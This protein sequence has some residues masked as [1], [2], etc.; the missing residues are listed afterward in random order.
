[1]IYGSFF[2]QKFLLVWKLEGFCVKIEYQNVISKYF[3][4]FFE[5]NSNL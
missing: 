1:L 2:F 4:V 5:L 3:L